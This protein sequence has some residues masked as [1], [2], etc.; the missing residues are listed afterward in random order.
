MLVQAGLCWWTIIIML[1]WCSWTTSTSAFY[2]VDQQTRNQHPNH[3]LT[4]VSSNA[5]FFSRDD[6]IITEVKTHLGNEEISVEDL[7]SAEKASSSNSHTKMKLHLLKKE[8]PV[9][10]AAALLVTS[11][12]D[13]LH[14]CSAARDAGCSSPEWEAE[15]LV[16]SCTSSNRHKP[17]WTD[18][19][20]YTGLFSREN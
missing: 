16:T 14:A 18:M 15:V 12:W 8:H 19:E 7:K 1:S 17:A 9:T 11:I 13:V 4:L 5:G 10:S 6:R 20:V 3:F 2:S